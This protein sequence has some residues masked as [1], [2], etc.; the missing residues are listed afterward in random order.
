[1]ENQIQDIIKNV[2][3]IDSKFI[4]NQIKKVLKK[5][6]VN[7]SA[8]LINLKNVVYCLYSKGYK[9]EFY[10]L[11]PVLLRL[12]Y[13]NWNTWV[14]IEPMLALI[15]FD[16]KKNATHQHF[17]DAALKKI[18]DQ[19]TTEALKRRCDVDFLVN[20][21]SGLDKAKELGKKTDIRDCL[22]LYLNELAI[23]Y[24]YGGSEKYPLAFLESEFLKSIDELNSIL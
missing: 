12:E 13:K 16:S 11:F 14:F 17:A 2:D 10:N 5:M 22:L 3:S 21:K 4:N 24:A 8:D 9:Q 6:S 15:Y 19:K 7:S 20:R 1:M 18:L 23:V